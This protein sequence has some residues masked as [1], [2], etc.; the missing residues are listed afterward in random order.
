[1]YRQLTSTRSVLSQVLLFLSLLFFM[2]A[3]SFLQ[4]NCRGLLTNIDDIND[5]TDQYDTLSF[6]LQETNLSTQNSNP[7][8]RWKMFRKDRT[9]AARASGGVAILTPKSLPAK[10][11]PLVTNLEAVAVQIC[12]DKLITVCSVYL[13]PS[14]VIPQAQLESLIDQLPPPFILMGDLNAHNVLWGSTRVDA[15]GKVLERILLSR[16]LCLLNTGAPTYVHS[17]TQ[18]FSAI[19]ISL[20]SPSLFQDM[21]W[22]VDQDPRGSD[23]FPVILNFHTTLNNIG[24]R[25]PRWKLSKADWSI[26]KKEATFDLLALHDMD[27]D[28]ANKIVTDMIINAATVSIPQTSGRLPRRPKP[29]WNSEC[30]R[31][32][33]VQNRAWGIFRR[34]PTAPNLLAFKKA[35]AKARWTRRQSKKESWATFVSSLN[36]NTPSKKVWERLRKIK[37][38]YASLSVPLLHVNG[39]PC[40]SLEEQ[41]DALGQHFQTVSSSSHYSKEFLKVK[42]AAEKRVIRTSGD[43]N[44][45]YNQPFTMAELLRALSISK[46][47]APGP[48]RITY[49]MLQHL[50]T[51]SQEELLNFFNFIWIEGHLPSCW[52]AATVIPFLKPGKDPSNPTSY[53]PI[54]LTSCLGK[55][56]ERMV[57]NR[58][59]YFLETNKLLSPYQCGFRAGRSTVDH[60]VRLESIV[61][62]AFIRSQH[63]I[64]VFF[65][66]EKA[67]DTAWRYGILQDIYSFGIRGRLLRCVADFLEGRKFRVQVGTVLSRPF[68]QENGVP[69]GSVLSVTLFIIKMNSIA[70]VIPPT[71]SFSLYVDDVQISCSSS[72]LTLCERQLQLTINR[73]VKWSTQN[74]FKFSPEKTVCVPFSRKRGMFPEPSLKMSNHE[75]EVRSEHKFLGLIFDRKL[76]FSAHI[77]DLKTRCI[78]SLNLLKVLAHRS[79]GADKETLYKIYMSIIRSRLDYGCM[80]YGS[81]R[82]SSLKRLDPIHHQGLRMALGAFR[83]SPVQSLYVEC[84]EWALDRRRFYLGALYALRVKGCPDHPALPTVLDTRYK[85]LFLNKPA[86]TRPLSMRILQGVEDYNFLHYNSLISENCKPIPPWQ[87]PPKHDFAMLRFPKRDTADICLQQE[88]ET[89]RESFGSHVEIYTDGSKSERGTACAMVSEGY[90]KTHNLNRIMSIFSAEVYAVIV[91]LNF[92]L[93]NHIAS[94]VIYTDSLSCAQALCGLT[95]TK[96]HLV[97]RARCIAATIASRGYDTMVCWVPSH[98]GIP[99]NER[100]DRAAVAALDADSTPFDIPSQDLK[101]FLRR[102]I[103]VNWQRTWDAEHENKL[104]I[105]KPNIGKCTFRFPNRLQEVLFS[106]LRLGHTFLTH[107]FLLRKEEPP[108]CRHCGDQ[109]SIAHILITCPLYETHRRRHFPLFYE[110]FLPFHPAFL[111]GDNAVVHFKS[112]LNFLNDIG[113]LKDL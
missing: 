77:K 36:Y 12:I 15:R 13:P 91:A 67:Y 37:G 43:D 55:T 74:G 60:L 94:S 2:R 96:N 21:E 63:C 59:V 23:H 65:D 51:A 90:T 106:R 5:L 11:V 46:V 72:N 93:Q 61:R 110:T 75:L 86:V 92:I 50:S 70:N 28:Q 3:K 87:P 69:Q 80:V 82:P 14:V 104:R 40:E 105:I 19:D 99:G 44:Q 20:C 76:T 100:A 4:W 38:D 7:F 111:L 101:P 34:Y 85:Q 103:N 64:S 49:T 98:V 56:F 6:C 79:W 81:A 32:R 95:R 108:S 8:R 57:N 1:M 16:S 39:I 24:K 97:Q 9:D 112:V 109:L 33:R 29:W 78:K 113:Y 89:L 17:A 22:V 83:T 41:A 62:E 48:D 84:N 27:V 107:G 10:D 18:S 68:V 47:T 52:K 25:P 102:A 73:L 58:L 53:R 26:F 35:R 30:E 31:T 88:F 45:P 54:A 66:L 71:V 42:A